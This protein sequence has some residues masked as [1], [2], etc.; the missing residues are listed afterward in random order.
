MSAP[1]NL[2]NGKTDSLTKIRLTCRSSVSPCSASVRPAMIRAA[3]LARGTPVAL[4]TNGVVREARGFTSSTYTTSF[5]IAYCTFIR[6]L[7][8]EGEA[9][10]PRVVA[11]RLEVGRR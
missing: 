3:T 7:H 2:R 10:P 4:L 9:E 1:G 8:A 11:D 5:L 6:P